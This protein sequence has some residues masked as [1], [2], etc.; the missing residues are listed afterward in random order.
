MPGPGDLPRSI[1]ALTRR[2]GIALADA[3]W[4]RS[5]QLLFERLQDL[6]RAAGKNEATGIPALPTIL[7][8]L[9]RGGGPSAHC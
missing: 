5:M 8:E 9:R 7:T 3:D 6:A 2:N 1:A 4:S